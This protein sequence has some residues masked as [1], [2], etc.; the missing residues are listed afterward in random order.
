MRLTVAPDGA[1]EG[2]KFAGFYMG[3]AAAAPG[4]HRFVLRQA[5]RINENT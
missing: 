1:M 5:S 3:F 4:E 2:A